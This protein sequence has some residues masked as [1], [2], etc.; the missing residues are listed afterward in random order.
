MVCFPSS[1][2]H[3]VLSE[4]FDRTTR[5]VGCDPRLEL[6]AH[7]ERQILSHEVLQ[8]MFSTCVLHKIWW[9]PLPNTKNYLREIVSSPRLSCNLLSASLLARHVERPCVRYGTTPLRSVR[10]AVRSQFALC[11]ECFVI[12][13]FK[14]VSLVL[15]D[16]GLFGCAVTGE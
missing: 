11:F 13:S 10:S 9:L 2:S 4:L 15:V 16:A 8:M 1:F 12:R 7:E 3:N 14:W 6:V 5:C